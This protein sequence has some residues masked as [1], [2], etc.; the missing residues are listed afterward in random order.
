MHSVV[1]CRCSLRQPQLHATAGVDLPVEIGRTGGIDS[2]N[3]W[4]GWMRAKK[5][6]DL[7]LRRDKV[8][9]EQ[10]ER[11]LPYDDEKPQTRIEHDPAFVRPPANA[12]IV[13]DR[14]PSPLSNRRHPLL[15]SRVVREMIVVQLDP[16]SGST[17][18]TGELFPQVAVRKEDRFSVEAKRRARRRRPRSLR[19]R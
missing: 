14:N 3:P 17:Q 2:S 13:R 8:A 18:N 4:A 11:R 5:P 7:R 12:P 16:Q 9:G 6:L 10:R 15:V 19:P 1:G